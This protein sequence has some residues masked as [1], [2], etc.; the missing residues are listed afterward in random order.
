M[1]SAR[2]L[3]AAVVFVVVWLEAA[4]GSGLPG[5]KVPAGPD[6]PAAT[7]VD[8]AGRRV[9]LPARPVRVVSLAPSVT[10]ILF[11]VGAGERVVGVTDFCND[12]PEAR[13]RPRVGGLIH[14][15]LERIASLHA[16]LAIATTAGNY[17]EDAEAIERLGVPVYTLKSGSLEEILGTILQVGRLVEAESSAERLVSGLR[18]RMA[19][20]RSAAEGRPRA[21]V[22]FVIEP[23][24]LISP[25][26]GTFV[27]EALRMAGADLVSGGAASGWN[28]IDFE[29]VIALDPDLILA[30][31]PHAAWAATLAGS[32]RWRLV[33]AAREGRV[34]VV[35]DAIQH[36]GPRL[37]DGMEEVAEV[38]SALAR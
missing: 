30:T 4:P 28:Q 31:Q 1:R 22:L 37:I 8:G 2:G 17:R 27:G 12:P 29:Q 32:A 9:R 13:L 38:L 19:R 23:E 3:V 20:V 35:S 15:D 16:D 7:V 34:R 5:E 24:P 18:A 14:P 36:P 21:R 26:P 33:R 10:E 6:G 25:G 11:A